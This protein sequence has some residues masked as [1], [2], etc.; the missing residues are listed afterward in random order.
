MPVKRGTE[1]P[2]I[3]VVLVTYKVAGNA[4]EI[5]IDTASQ[6][7]VTPQVETTDAVKLII[8]GVLKAQKPKKST[9]TGNTIVLTDNV[10]TPELVKALQGGVIKWWTSAEQS[11]ESNTP[12]AFDLQLYTASRG[13]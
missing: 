5:A 1:I 11:T 4:D 7:A 9:I 8:K 12:T 2:T 3:D 6:I 10:F 13:Q